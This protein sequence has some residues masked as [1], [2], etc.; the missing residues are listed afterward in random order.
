MLLY[1]IAQAY[2]A[3]GNR[4]RALLFYR[5]YLEASADAAHNIAVALKQVSEP[6]ESDRTKGELAKTL[7]MPELKDSFQDRVIS[8][9]DLRNPFAE[10][11]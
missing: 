2:R 7:C 5:R 3:A 11:Q 10:N 6:S 4:E 8:R 1:N 9:D